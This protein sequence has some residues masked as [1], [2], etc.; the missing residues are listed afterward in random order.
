MSIF[1]SIRIPLMGKKTTLGI[2]IGTASIKI[3]ELER[4]K[5]GVSLKN[6]GILESKGHL[7]RLNNAIQ[8]S[9][10]KIVG[11]DTSELLKRLLEE[12]KPGTKD[13][14]ASLPAY[15]AF[16]SLVEIP[17]MS[18]EETAQAMTF[19]AKAFVPL[20]LTEV[21]IDWLPIREIDDGKGGKKQQILLV[22]IPNK[23]IQTYKDIFRAAGLTLRFL[24]V[25][26]LSLA[27]IL[28]DGDPTTSL[29]VDIGARSTSIA[30]AGGGTLKYSAQTDYAAS[31]LTQAVSRGYGVDVNRAEDLKRQKGLIGTGGQYQVSTLMLPYLDVILNE[32]RRIK[33][34]FEK[35]Y[36][37]KVER[38]ILT[39]GGANL[40]G[41]E[42]YTSQQLDLLTIKGDSFSKISTPQEFGPSAASIGSQLSVA[43]GLAIRDSKVKKK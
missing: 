35:T 38:V 41:I 20:P 37:E 12:I 15:S 24:E 19:Q 8:T 11:N 36:K 42:K 6:Y 21:A 10:L 5:E 43:L 25:E 40:L 26:T 2:D 16:S 22:S 3:A 7:D 32:A 30:V 14:V 31:S 9:S 18:K 27:R 28:T 33:D 1:K 23:Q 17:V 34:I 29:I 13:V 39:G 4:T